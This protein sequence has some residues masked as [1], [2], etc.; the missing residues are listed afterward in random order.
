[1]RTLAR[2]FAG[3]YPRQWRARYGQEFDAL[4]QDVNL[5][6]RDVF[7]VA[8][9]A[10]GGNYMSEPAVLPRIVD[11]ASRDI[12]HGYELETAV[13]YPREDGSKM[14]VRY[15]YREVDLGDSYFMLRHS[16][17]GA[18]PAQTM[19]VCG[20]KGEIDGNF[21]TDQTE[22]L[23]LRPDGSVDRTEQTVKT[24]LKYDGLRDRLRERYRSGMQAGQTPDQIHQKIVE[25]GTLQSWS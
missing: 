23:V 6:W 10:L 7:G 15:F 3:L 2:F 14:M 25:E 16:T 8:L 11:L 20:R 12:P 17:R 24:W 22:M 18:E 9:S 13:E 19:L 4:L 5:T 1:M 21:R